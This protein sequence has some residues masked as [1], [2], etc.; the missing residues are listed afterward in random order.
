VS[1]HTVSVFTRRSTRILDDIHEEIRLSREQ[2][3]DLRLFIRDITR[4][5]ER[6]FAGMHEDQLRMRARLDDMGARLED[7]GAEIR[8]NTQAT[9]SVLD[10]MNE[11]WGPPAGPAAA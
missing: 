7:M 6:F 11:N 10:R 5:S 4:R 1:C 9:L 3:A 2:Q 8:A